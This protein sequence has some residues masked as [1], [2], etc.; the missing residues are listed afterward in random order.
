MDDYVHSDYAQKLLPRAVGYS[1]ALLDYFFRGKLVAA[2]S[3]H[4]PSTSTTLNFMVKNDTPGEEMTGGKLAL[5]LRY[6][7]YTESGNTLIA[8]NQDSQYIYQVVEVSQ[9]SVSSGTATEVSFNLSQSL[10]LWT[11]ELSAQIVYRGVLGNEADAVAVTPW[12]GLSRLMQDIA[13]SLPTSGVYAANSSAAPFTSIKVN[14]KNNLPNGQTMTNGT[15]SLY[16]L[17]R[18]ATSDPFQSQPVT[19]SPATGYSFIKVADSSITSLSTSPTELTFNFS[20]TPLPL[21]ATDVYLYVVYQGAVSDGT[22]TT[23]NATVAGMIDISEPTPVD[24]FNNADKVCVNGAWYTAGTPATLAL[25]DAGNNLIANQTDLYAHNIT[26]I[27]AKASTLD[28]ATPASSSN[29]TL[30][31]SDTVTGGNVKRLGYILTDYNFKYSNL[32]DWLDVNPA[33]PWYTVEQAEMYIGTAVK[34][35]DGIY[36]G[37]FNIS[38]K[39]IWWGAGVVNDNDTWP[40]GTTADSSCGW[41][42]LP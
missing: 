4:H 26:N 6:K 42:N 27:F 36:P 18:T 13:L 20:A 28:N 29:Y 14:A 32:E 35:Q 7:Q 10:P 41:N 19:S 24:V 40:S 1:A 25:R 38:G 39:K 3:T 21:W 17:Y 33:D 15:L 30:H 22:I 12:L 11:T 16:L 5:V 8:P 23:L 2:L 31:T 34:N 37:M 9:Q